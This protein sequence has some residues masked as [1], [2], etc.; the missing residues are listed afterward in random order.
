[1]AAY[2]LS[3][4]WRA[5]R[6]FPFH[7]KHNATT[8]GPA[9][10]SNRGSSHRK[11]IAPVL[12]AQDCRR[13]D[14]HIV[15]HHAPE[16][17]LKPDA[18]LGVRSGARGSSENHPMDKPHNEGPEPESPG[19]TERCLLGQNARRRQ[20]EIQEPVP[21]GVYLPCHRLLL[22]T[23]FARHLGRLFVARPLGQALQELVGASSGTRWDNV[24]FGHRN[25]V[26]GSARRGVRAVTE[27]ARPT[28]L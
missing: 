2:V 19:P 8:P 26:T 5:R 15:G 28:L 16:R 1:M 4:A 24:G 14:A 17:R 9:R 11:P 18:S 22:G 12:I 23:V 21:V 10:T 25:F 27:G 6:V 13:G 7:H 3:P 20:R